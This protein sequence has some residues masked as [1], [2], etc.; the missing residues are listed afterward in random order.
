MVA[1][2]AYHYLHFFI[3]TVLQ[4]AYTTIVVIHTTVLLPLIDRKGPAHQVLPWSDLPALVFARRPA[5]GRAVNA[6]AAIM[7]DRMMTMAAA[8][9]RIVTPACGWWAVVL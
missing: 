4:V 1:Y 3:L 2:Y 9:P 7:N 6:Q 5:R 8:A